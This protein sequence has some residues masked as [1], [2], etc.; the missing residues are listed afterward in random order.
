MKLQQD[1]IEDVGTGDVRGGNGVDIIMIHC[2]Y[3]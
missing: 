2:I 3:V 1:I